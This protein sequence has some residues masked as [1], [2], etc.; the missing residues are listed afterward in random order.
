MF[1]RSRIRD[2]GL[3]R[4][5]ALEVR[6]FE[7]FRIGGLEATRGHGDTGTRGRGEGE[8]RGNGDAGTRGR[9]SA[10]SL[11]SGDAENYLISASP[12]FPVPRVSASPRHKTTS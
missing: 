3:Q 1:Q 6:L 5:I 2:P 7:S 12:L 8:T 4:N 10:E 9:G 11:K